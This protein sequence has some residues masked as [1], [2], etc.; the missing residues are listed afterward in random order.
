MMK[1]M[2]NKFMITLGNG[3][4]Q[5]SESFIVLTPDS[6][7][8]LLNDMDFLRKV[9]EVLWDMANEFCD[10]EEPEELFEELSID[11][12]LPWEDEFNKYN[13]SILYEK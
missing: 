6:E 5:I 9:D 7:E 11:S 10:E 13:L 8:V 3:F 4:P 12:I 2:K 1:E